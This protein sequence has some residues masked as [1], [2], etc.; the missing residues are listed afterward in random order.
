M[1]HANESSYNLVNNGGGLITRILNNG[2]HVHAPYTWENHDNPPAINSVTGADMAVENDC[3]SAGCQSTGTETH[4][5]VYN[6]NCTANGP[7]F[8]VVTGKCR[9]L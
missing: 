1:V 3:S 8:D 5:L 9:G 7:W 6:T 4:L 2:G